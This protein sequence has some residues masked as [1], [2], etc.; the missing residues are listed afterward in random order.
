MD[1]KKKKK[2]LFSEFPPVS[3]KE[4]EELI[5][6]DLKG[7]DYDKKL[8]WKTTEGFD[9]RPYYRQEDLTALDWLKELSSGYAFDGATKKAANNWIIRQDF[10]MTDIEE[11]NSCA[12]EAI[13]RGVD[14]VGFCVKEI[15]THK[16]MS[17][18]LSGIDLTKTG[19]HFVSS[20][21][22]PL[23]IELF[24]YE[25]DEQ[26]LKGHK[27]R[28]SINFDPISY[29]LLNGDFY[30]SQINNFDEAEYLLNSGKKH[31]PGFRL[32]TVNGHYFQ[33]AGSTLVQELA[34][35]LASGNEYLA[36]LVTKGFPIDIVA[37]KIQ[38]GM[39]T[40]SNYFMEIAKLRAARLLWARI[41][42][43]YGPKHSDTLQMFIHSVTIARNK[44][45]YDP[46]V[47]ILRTTTEGMAAALGNA[48]SISIRPFDSSYKDPDDF[49]FRM[50]RNQQFIFREEAHLNKTIDPGAG[51]YYIET[52]TDSIA[53]HAWKLFRFIESKGGFIECIKTG[54][55]QEEIEKSRKEDEV[56][57]S[58]R[59]LIRIGTNQYPSLPETMLDKIQIKTQKQDPTANTKYKKLIISRETEAFEQLRL[60]TESFV[61]EGNKKP[62][63]F[64]FAFG[65]PVMRKARAAFTTNFF[66]CAGYNILD[67]PGYKNIETGIKAAV[68]S[69]AE[70]I[71]ICSSDEEYENTV[72]GICHAIK[73]KSP[74][75]TIIVAGNPVKIIDS[76][77]DSGVD[78]FIHLR[79]NLYETLFKY[80]QKLGIL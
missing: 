31:L 51:S 56:D 15:T 38:F 40:G 35:S 75:T 65:N 2:K 58:K 21:S 44:T 13:K 27:I 62:S 9:V 14:D 64:L 43:Q 47:N 16:Q 26:K 52:L 66:G 80:Q 73:S 72:P 45:L 19:V 4:W 49:S 77:G 61:L 23:S 74:V 55:I 30:V 17:R 25:L 54:Y 32:I 50:A 28:G 46:Y 76:L 6:K 68:S 63:V 71:V 8:L 39:G 7:A 67:H 12:L 22:Y 79:S 18:L 78:D 34:Y 48:D 36:G 53:Q 1:P 33:E 11:A 59:K 41:V 42:E 70:I 20:R 3:T 60:A 57:I 10:P 24:F 37:P 29:L 5:R 69:H